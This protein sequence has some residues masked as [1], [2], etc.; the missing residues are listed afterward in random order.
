MAIR[1]RLEDMINTT[2]FSSPLTAF[3]RIS[4]ILNY[5]HGES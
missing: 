2:I 4:N 3:A 1:L 5:F